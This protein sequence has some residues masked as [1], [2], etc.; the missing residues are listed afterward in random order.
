MGDLRPASFLN[1]FPLF[2]K[3]GAVAKSLDICRIVTD[4]EHRVARLMNLFISLITFI[5]K[6]HISHGKNFVDD[7][8]A[9]DGAKG[10]G[11]GQAHGHPR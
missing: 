2:E 7:E 3:E 8:Q 5:S 4:H 9:S 6:F 11:I 1:Y 10:H